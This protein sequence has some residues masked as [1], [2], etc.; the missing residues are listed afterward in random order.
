MFFVGR[1]PKS[2][3]VGSIFAVE[4]DDLYLIA[5]LGDEDMAARSKAGIQMQASLFRRAND[6]GPII[7]LDGNRITLL[8]NNP[9]FKAAR[10][11]IH[12]SQNQ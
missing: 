5:V 4:I 3:Q 12:N 6:K 2:I 7:E 9:Y 1:Q 8:R 11:I 10:M